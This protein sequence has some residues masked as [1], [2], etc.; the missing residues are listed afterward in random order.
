[1]WLDRLKAGVDREEAAARLWE[2][3]FSQLVRYARRHLEGRRVVIDEEDVAL[4]A[5]H[6]FVR[7]S[8]SGRFPNLHDRT[9]LWAVLL[10][11]TA[12]KARNAVR[13]ENREKRGGGMVGYGIAETDSAASG[14][15]L[16]TGEPDP[17]EA[18]AL[19]EGT[20]E[21]LRALDDDEL[22]QVELL[23]R[24][25]RSNAETGELRRI[26]QLSLE[27]HSNAEIG[28]RIGKSVATVERK[29]RRIRNIW[30]A[31]GAR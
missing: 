23:A 5:F 20:E 3:Y 17:A 21:L 4:S 6:A 12:N 15:P 27:G 22:Q 11:M 29:L 13:D 31:R 30:A 14:V 10:R 16:P 26:V 7:A 24:V 1:V 18:A 2:R 19:A 28:V 25:S 9:D 8:D